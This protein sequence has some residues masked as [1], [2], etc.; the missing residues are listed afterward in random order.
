MIVVV[1][2]EIDYE[3]ITPT[4]GFKY[5]T[6]FNLYETVKINIYEYFLTPMLNDAKLGVI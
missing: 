4:N 5:A 6:I 1:V 3:C 2:V